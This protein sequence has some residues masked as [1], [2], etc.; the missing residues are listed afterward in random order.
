MTDLG[1]VPLTREWSVAK[2]AAVAPSEAGTVV[3]KIPSAEKRA[4]SDSA[5]AVTVAGSATAANWAVP[6]T[7]EST[8][9]LVS[10]VG[11]RAFSDTASGGAVAGAAPVAKKAAAGSS[12]ANALLL[13]TGEK[14]ILS[15]ANA[16]P[17]AKKAVPVPFCVT[18]ASVPSNDE[19][20]FLVSTP[21]STEDGRALSL[22]R[23]KGPPRR[24]AAAERVPSHVAALRV[25]ALRARRGA[26]V[27]EH[28]V[29]WCTVVCKN[30]YNGGFHSES[31]VVQD[32]GQCRRRVG[33]HAA[34][35]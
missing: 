3:V 17:P 18:V 7:P 2:E 34:G 5:P 24:A 19:R 6:A 14:W 1:R 32:N 33:P 27:G 28:V 25:T 23:V 11:K 30:G 4:F 10:A 9:L 20:A 35:S 21:A 26:G 8:A 12:N 15:E 31:W 13:P 29:A 16:A 22:L